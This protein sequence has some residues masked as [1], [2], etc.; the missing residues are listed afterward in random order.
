MVANAAS[1][2]DMQNLRLY[3]EKTYDD[4]QRMLVSGNAYTAAPVI[5]E[6]DFVMWG[7]AQRKIIASQRPQNVTVGVVRAMARMDNMVRVQRR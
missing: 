6:G 2:L 4:I 1:L 5:R 3:K 7:E